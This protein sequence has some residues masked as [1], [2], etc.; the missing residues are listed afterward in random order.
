[1]NLGV[2]SRNVGIALICCAVFM[3]LSA[4]VA[5]LDGFDS[6]FSPLL[7]SALLTMMGGD[8]KLRLAGSSTLCSIRSDSMG[9]GGS[10]TICGDGALELAGGENAILVRA[11]GAPDFVRVEP[12]ARLTASSSGSVIRVVDSA[13]SDGVIVVDTSE[14]QLIAYDSRRAVTD[15]LTDHFA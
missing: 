2:I 14:P 1:M 7:L 13:L 10:L 12:Q 15:V 9:R 11:G 4:L 8:F 6:S 3:F 5:A